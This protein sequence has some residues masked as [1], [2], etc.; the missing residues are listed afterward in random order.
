LELLKLAE[1][2]GERPENMG[3]YA[4]FD[5]LSICQE[6]LGRFTPLED[7]IKGHN[8]TWE[9]VIIEAAVE[10]AKTKL[11]MYLDPLLEWFEKVLSDMTCTGDRVGAQL[12][13]VQSDIMDVK[14]KIAMIAAAQPVGGAFAAMSN[15]PSP[16]SMAASTLAEGP[17]GGI[18]QVASNG[19][20]L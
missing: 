6:E 12:K 1:L 18:S 2:V 11:R 20:A 16:V 3:T 7:Y 17:A 13:R 5:M 14:G 10:K 15:T 4:I 8:N 9:E 19:T